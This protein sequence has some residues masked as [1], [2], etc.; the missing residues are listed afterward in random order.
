M[1]KEDEL[2]KEAYFHLHSFILIK[3][4]TGPKILKPKT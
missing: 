1:R 2:K 4:N 3:Q